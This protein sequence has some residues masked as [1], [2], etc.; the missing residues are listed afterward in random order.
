MRSLL[1]AAAMLTTVLGTLPAAAVTHWR[2][3]AATPGFGG[4]REELQ[5]LVDREG[6]VRVNH[7]CAVV[8]DV[9]EPPSASS[10]GNSRQLIVHW[11]E[12]GRI[13][14]YGPADNG[15]LAPGNRDEGAD[16]DLRNDVVATEKEIGGSTTRVTRA[17][18]NRTI[19]HCR[20]SGVRYTII[21]R[22]GR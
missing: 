8:E 16:I 20:I 5:R 15:R 22:S 10:E 6:R 7:L 17:F 14:S 13:Y 9:R 21:R 12:G 2:K 4:V 3:P 18:V 11:V 1:L 19:A